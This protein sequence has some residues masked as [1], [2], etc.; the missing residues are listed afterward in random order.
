MIGTRPFPLPPSPPPRYLTETMMFKLSALVAGAAAFV[1]SPTPAARTTAR[2]AVAV[3]DP[4]VRARAARA[5]RRAA[6]ARAQRATRPS[7]P[8]VLDV[9]AAP[10]TRSIGI[11]VDGVFVLGAGPR[12]RTRAAE[13]IFEPRRGGRSSVARRPP[14]LRRRGHARRGR[15]GRLARA[16]LRG[17][18]LP[19]VRGR[20]R[21]PRPRGHVPRA[22]RRLAQPLGARPPA[23]PKSRRRHPRTSAR[24]AP[25]GRQRPRWPRPGG[26]TEPG[27]PRGI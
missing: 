15:A 2:Q 21:A 19:R 13:R 17:D 16:R 14:P 12:P 1:A 20:R 18:A 6:A 11:T 8:Q 9:A 10:A 7:S 24:G 25:K 4:P 5:A 26:E 22:R 3:L 27:E 23:R